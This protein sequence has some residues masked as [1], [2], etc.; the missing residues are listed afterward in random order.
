M[1][2]VSRALETL[3]ERIPV[4]KGCTARQFKLAK[5]IVECEDG[6]PPEGWTRALIDAGYSEMTADKAAVT[7]RGR[8]GTLAAVSTLEDARRGKRDSAAQILGTALAKAKRQL[9]SETH[10]LPTLMG[11]AK[12][13]ADVVEKIPEE[14]AS[15]DDHDRGTARAFIE[16][17]IRGYFRLLKGESTGNNQGFET[18]I[19]VELLDKAILAA[20]ST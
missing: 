17:V 16:T 9:D 8:A 15:V 5:R 14:D 20:Q 1:P 18:E 6:V 19:N 10:D 2:T 13:A 4:P 12:L 7:I 11:T 3:P